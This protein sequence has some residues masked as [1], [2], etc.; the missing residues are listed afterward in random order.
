[1]Y[2]SHKTLYKTCYLILIFLIELTY[3][4]ANTS[5][6]LL[7]VHPTLLST[8]LAAASKANLPKSRILLF[9]EEESPTIQGVQDWR[10]MIASIGEA[11]K[12][13]WEMLN[14]KEA[15]KRTAVLNYSSGY[16]SGSMS[17]Y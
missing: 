3:Q 11:E 13:E 4:L 10:T 14:G 1:L 15:R 2:L 7:L 16:A 17:P 12:W 6:S 9:S 5:A 8:A